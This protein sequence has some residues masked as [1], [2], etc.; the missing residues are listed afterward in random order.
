LI[1]QRPQSWTLNKNNDKKG[2][3][4]WKRRSQSVVER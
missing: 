1:K 2:I 3:A 4:K